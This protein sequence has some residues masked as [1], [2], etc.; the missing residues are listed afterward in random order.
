MPCSEDFSGR[1]H[2]LP[3]AVKGR[4]SIFDQ[5]NSPRVFESGTVRPLDVDWDPKNALFRH[6]QS[7]GGGMRIATVRKNRKKRS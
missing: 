3:P 1:C 4:C 6:Q 7:M 5:I 2:F